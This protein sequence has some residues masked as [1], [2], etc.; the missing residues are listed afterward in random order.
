MSA[1]LANWWKGRVGYSIYELILSWWRH[2]VSFVLS[3]G[4][5]VLAL[6]VYYLVFVQEARTPISEFAQRLE[7]NSLDTR[8]RYKP[9]STTADSRIVIIDIDQH[10]Q[11]V[12]GRWPFSRAYFAKMLNI[13]HDE[14]ASVAAFDITF[15]RP[16]QTSA[17][18]RELYASLEQRK[19]KGESIDPKVLS[20][21][22][23][24]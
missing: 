19:R 4:I 14:R 10:A 9:A 23:A 18:L 17:P 20:E 8:F 7:L 6:A 5:T 21:V 24:L 2:R 13:L 11:E 15:S 12:L 22:A 3:L 1:L 16:D